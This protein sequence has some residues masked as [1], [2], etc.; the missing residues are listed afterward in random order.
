MVT[1]VSLRSEVTSWVC[2]F[3]LACQSSWMTERWNLTIEDLVDSVYQV[4]SALTAIQRAKISGG[5]LTK[6]KIVLIDI[7]HSSGCLHLKFTKSYLHAHRVLVLNYP[8]KQWFIMD[9]LA[10]YSDAF[11]FIK[12]KIKLRICSW[13]WISQNESYGYKVHFMS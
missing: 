1:V 11:S 10:A 13:R 8:D 2:R 6:G 4:R 9:F 7:I 5:H 12:L 3:S